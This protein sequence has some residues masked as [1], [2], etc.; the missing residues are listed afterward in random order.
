VRDAT[1]DRPITAYGAF[2][3]TI[4]LL[5]VEHFSV[6]LTE[7]AR[8]SPLTDLV[9]LAA[10]KVLA[11]SIV[12]FAIV[13]SHARESP[14]R[15]ALG[16]SPPAIHHVL[17][18]VVAGAGI[19]PVLSALDDRILARFPYDD[20]EMLA[21]VEKLVSSAPRAALVI[22]M[23]VVI[24]VASEV[25]FRGLLFGG[26]NGS[27][28][29][30]EAIVVTAFLFALASLDL[31]ALPST[32]VL[33]LALGWLRAKS[34]S[35]F[36][37]IVAIVAF[38]GLSAIAILQGRDPLGDIAYPPKWV[39]AGGLLALLSLVAMRRRMAFVS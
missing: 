35:V 30:R 27:G 26:L 25:F 39:V 34:G 4:V 38:R 13:R 5:T 19:S 1:L 21:N 12:A 24:P 3:W 11:T 29:T 16:V 7:A 31:R 37:A 18:A 15:R 14:L 22:G 28:K 17:L 23:F 9:S 8:G 32:L 33:G 20:P 36:P 2:F 10:C 6:E